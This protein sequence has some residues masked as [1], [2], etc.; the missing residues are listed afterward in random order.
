MLSHLKFEKNAFFYGGIVGCLV[1]GFM[2]FQ[3]WWGDHDW[4]YLQQGI[5][6][7]DGLFE[8]RYSQHLFTV[9]LF[10]GQ[11]LPILTSVVSLFAL[12]FMGYLAAVYLGFPADKRSLILFLCLLVSLPYTAI[13]FYYLFIALPLMLYAALGVGILFL[14]K[15]PFRWQKFVCGFVGAVLLLGSYPP[16]LALVMTI[17]AGQKLICYLKHKMELKDIFMACLFFG[18]QF[19]LAYAVTREI[20][21]HLADQGILNTQMYNLQVRRFDE[22]PEQI[23]KEGIAPLKN[24]GFFYQTLGGQY[25]VFYASVLGVAIFKMFYLFKNK[26]IVFCG[27]LGLF[28]VSRLP[29]LISA[30]AYLAEYR[31]AYW[32]QLGLL[33]VALC[34]LFDT[35]QLWQR[36]LLFAGGGFFLFLFVRTDYDIQK[37]QYLK[38]RAERLYHTRLSER[39]FFHPNFDMMHS[40]VT[41]S[42]GYPNFKEHICG[43]NCSQF[44]NDVLGHTVMPADLISVLFWDDIHNPVGMGRMGVWGKRLWFVGD[45]VS[46]SEE[47]VAKVKDI[48]WWMSFLSRVCLLL[49]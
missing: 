9:L 48:R 49:L 15:P 23:L 11:V 44:N 42:I 5:A 30:N 7:T 33:I 2:I 24:I 28:L 35:K 10:D 21:R 17:F 14:T 43:E 47:I 37:V 38:F 31:V 16:I 22:L 6:V 13:V 40:Y 19:L 39:V 1:W 34:F 3:F 26:I 25:A 4:S 32:G 8:A 46:K 41:L 36:N 27:V 18:G 20:W 45:F 12:S 29:F